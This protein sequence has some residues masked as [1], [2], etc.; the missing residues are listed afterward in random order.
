M[1]ELVTGPGGRCSACG[2]PQVWTMAFGEMYVACA[3]DCEPSLPGLEPPPLY[4]KGEE[5]WVEHWEPLSE[6][7]GRADSGGEANESEEGTSEPPSR[8]LSTLWTG[9][10]VDGETEE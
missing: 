7:E 8:W 4:V 10:P 2:G 1:S 9:G 6:V 3:R 5:L